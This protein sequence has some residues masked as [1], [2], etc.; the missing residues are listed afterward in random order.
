MGTDSH[1]GKHNGRYMSI[2]V[3]E[4]R[5]LLDLSDF[6]AVIIVGGKKPK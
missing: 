2:T 3:L 4:L 5:R 1:D 6:Y